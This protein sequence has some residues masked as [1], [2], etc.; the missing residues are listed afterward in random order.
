MKKLKIKPSLWL[1][2]Y[3]KP[4]NKKRFYFKL[5]AY[6]AWDA[7]EQFTNNPNFNNYDVVGLEQLIDEFII[8]NET[9]G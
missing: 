3:I 2:A 8:P 7:L 4:F 6:S 1:I 5:T 9:N